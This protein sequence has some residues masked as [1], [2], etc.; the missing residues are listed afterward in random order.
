MHTGHE[1]VEQAVLAVNGMDC[2]SCVAHVEGALTAVPGVTGASVNLAR[3]RAVV[4]FDPAR[5]QPQ[6]LADAV[7]RVGYPA[8]PELDLDGANVEQQ[9]VEHQAAHARAWFYR[10]MIGIALWLPVELLHWVLHL[11]THPAH[12]GAERRAAPGFFSIPPIIWIALITSTIALIYIGSAFYK[13]AFAALKRRTSNMDTLIAMGASVAY[14]YSL[15]ALVGYLAGI[16]HSLPALYFMESAGLLALISLGHWLEARARNSAGSAIRELLNL[17]P[18][19]ALRLGSDERSEFRVQGS[20]NA[21]NASSAHSSSSLNPSSPRTLNS[22]SPTPEPSEVPVAELKINDRILVRPGDRVAIDGVVISGASSIDESILTGESMPVLRKV[23]DEVIGGTINGDGRLVVRVTRTGG[24]TA[25]A[26]IV[27][28]VDTA[29]STKPP[30]QKLADRIAAVFVPSVLAIALLTGI[31]WY[32][33]GILTHADAAHIWAQIARTVCSV[34]IIACPCA[35]GL[36]IPAAVMVGTGRGAQRGILIRDIDALQ[37]AERVKTVVLD[38]TGTLTR[39][40]PTVSE[41]VS[42]NG[43]SEMELLTLA[44]GA[45]RYSE[46]PV[47]RAIVAYARARGINDLPEP[48]SFNNEPGL[49]VV[50]TVRGRE[51]LVGNPELLERHQNGDAPAMRE[52]P[53]S[54]GAQTLVYIASRDAAGTVTPLGR[55]AVADELKPDSAAAVKALHDLG[56]HTVLLTGDNEP[57]A[58]AIAQQVGIEDIH[59]NVRPAGKADVVRQLQRERNHLGVEARKAVGAAMN[60][61]A[62]N[63]AAMNR[64]GVAMI[65]DGVNDAPA[66]AQ[67]DLGIAIGSGSDVAKETGGIVLVGSSLRGAASAIRLSRATMRIIRQNLFFAFIYNVLAIPLAAMGLL[68]PL[69]AAAAMALSDITVIGNALRLR[70]ARID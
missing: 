35:L 31:G 58:R 45:E 57:T 30:V 41:V 3:G 34:L 6:Q 44:A 7:T 68:N 16:W 53:A 20:G 66:L 11:T 52:A 12:A 8:A 18:P 60:R 56:L 24:E 46:H 61:A 65:G 70:R 14:L 48:E 36:A 64:A 40:K 37:H 9:R 49:G 19:T 69:I 39:G 32:L 54:P 47:A 1:H 33:H 15:I 38:K 63:R 17:A 2:A 55:I 43:I 28:L 5:T 4:Q 27:K 25:L 23:G 59:A 13:S 22:S 51:L 29:Q 67:A 62:M 10:A 21:D 42:L 50:A 26:Q